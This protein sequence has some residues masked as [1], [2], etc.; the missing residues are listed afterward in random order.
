VQIKSSGSRIPII[1]GVRDFLGER[2][3]GAIGVPGVPGTE[4]IAD[5]TLDTSP[6]VDAL[7][8]MG[9]GTGN[10]SEPLETAATL[11]PEGF[12]PPSEIFRDARAP[13]TRVSDACSFGSDFA[14]TGDDAGTGGG[15]PSRR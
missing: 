8:G 7:R 14:L 9:T 1:I 2:C 5:D 4:R 3:V 10:G 11:S 15:V 6:S 12:D 13:S